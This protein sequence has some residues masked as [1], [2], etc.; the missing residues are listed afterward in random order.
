MKKASL[1]ISL[2]AALIIAPLAAAETIRYKIDPVHSGIT[3]KVRH[4]INQ[5]PGTFTDFEGEI[6]FNPENPAENKAIATIHVNTVNTRND[7][8]DNHLRSDDFFGAEDFPAMEY[9]SDEW[10]PMGDGRFHV[11]GHLT[12]LGK[13]YPVEMMVHYLG[14]VEGNN[15]LRSGWV[16]QAAIDRTQW[17]MDYG[18]GGPLGRT[19]QIELNIQGHRKD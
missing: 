1:F 11:T 13:T 16:G 14:E 8:R 4:F 6:H 9:E 19:V 17:G 7:R 18:V 15:I 12:L 2:L 3:F 10:H 5:V